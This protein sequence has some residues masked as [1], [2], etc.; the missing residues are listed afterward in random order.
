M[1]FVV[2]VEVFFFSRLFPVIQKVQAKEDEQL[3]VDVSID[4]KRLGVTQKVIVAHF[5]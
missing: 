4:R 3:L 2:A 5:I 1:E